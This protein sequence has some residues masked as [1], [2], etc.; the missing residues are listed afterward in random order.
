MPA[1]TGSGLFIVFKLSENYFA[2]HI[3]EVRE[4]IEYRE[5]KKIHGSYPDAYQGMINI[6]GD[7]V[8]VVN[9][10]KMLSYMDTGSTG[11]LMVIR[12]H[13][14][15]IAVGIDSAEFVLKIPGEEA[16]QSTPDNP[17]LPPEFME[18]VYTH[19]ERLINIVRL[20]KFLE[21]QDTTTGS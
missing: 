7:I 10:K 21:H 6:R 9:L 2:T 11:L 12:C 1:E 8:T 4:L 19:E 20:S 14:G 5:P 3:E 17:N 13:S 18:G 15:L 16:Q